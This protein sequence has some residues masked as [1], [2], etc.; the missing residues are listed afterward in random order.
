MWLWLIGGKLIYVAATPLSVDV[1]KSKVRSCIRRRRAW[2]VVACN[3]VAVPPNQGCLCLVHIPME[4]WRFFFFSMVRCPWVWGNNF[5]FFPLDELLLM[6][7][8]LTTIDG[9][10]VSNSAAAVRNKRGD[11][12]GEEVRGLMG[13]PLPSEPRGLEWW[14]YRTNLCFVNMAAGRTAHKHK[15][16]WRFCLVFSRSQQ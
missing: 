12:Q 2:G 10:L 15:P 14:I 5:N 9:T 13:L 6:S 7:N 16:I 1:N 3:S 4:I 11:R 8:Y